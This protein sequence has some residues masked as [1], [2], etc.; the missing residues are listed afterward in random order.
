MH[1]IWGKSLVYQKTTPLVLWYQNTFCFLQA[2]QAVDLRVV[3]ASAS[4]PDIILALSGSET[5][6]AARTR[7]LEGVMLAGP[8]EEDLEFALYMR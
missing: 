4:N 8:M 7:F 5:S 2:G 6:V 3:T 1:L